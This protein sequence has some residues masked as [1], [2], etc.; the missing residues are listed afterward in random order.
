M[1]FIVDE[2][3]CVGDL[4][5]Q[6]PG[7]ARVLDEKGI[8]FCCTG[9]RSLRAACDARGLDLKGVLIALEQGLDEGSLEPVVAWQVAALPALIAHIVSTHHQYIRQQTPHIQRW[10]DRVAD[11]HGEARPEVMRIRHSF[12]ALAS[13]LSQHMAKE[14]LVLFPAIERVAGGQPAVGLRRGGW[15][16]EGLAHP[17]RQMMLEHSHSGHDLADIRRASGDFTPPPE[18]CTTFRALYLA[19]EEF[20]TDLRQ[21]V[22]LENNILF[23]RALALEAR[24]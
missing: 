23:P 14:E 13:E 20:E 11:A 24:G 10:L 19:L 22:H 21:H 2:T 4:A 3:T 9:R 5:V 6:I 17:V 1:S 15:G 12:T 8:D 18:A 16:F 7:A